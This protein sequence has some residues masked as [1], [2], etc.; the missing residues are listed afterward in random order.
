MSGIYKI[1]NKSNNKC[2][3]G[4]TINFNDRRNLH[5]SKLKRGKHHSIILQR[6]YDKYG[7]DNFEFIILEECENDNL[8]E[9]EQ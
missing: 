6:A 1:L 3:I 2:Y 9:R 4:S 7:I 5:F 8:L